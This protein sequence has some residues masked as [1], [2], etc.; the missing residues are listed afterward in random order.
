MVVV[1]SKVA[2]LGCVCKQISSAWKFALHQESGP[3]M[4]T[5]LFTSKHDQAQGLSLQ[6]DKLSMEV[7]FAPGVRPI[8]PNTSFH[9]RT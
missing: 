7:G 1:F 2:P 9:I 6:A 4:Q 3:Y 8:H 5:N